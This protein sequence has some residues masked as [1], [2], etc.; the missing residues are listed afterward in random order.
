MQGV[1]ARGHQPLLHAVPRVDLRLALAYRG[2]WDAV[3]V[4]PVDMVM[5]MMP[6]VVVVVVVVVVVISR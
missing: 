3:P 5:L 2:R 6:M 1:R 4:P